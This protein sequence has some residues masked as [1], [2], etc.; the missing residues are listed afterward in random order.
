[1]TQ[2]GATNKQILTLAFKIIAVQREILKTAQVLET[3]R[4]GSTEVVPVQLKILELAVGLDGFR[5]RPLDVVVGH[6][7]KF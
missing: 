4:Q 2:S 6:V 5:E 7:Q 3:P 1:M